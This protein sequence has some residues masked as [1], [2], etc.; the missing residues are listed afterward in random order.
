MA[1]HVPKGTWVEVHR[2]VLE[3][4]ERAPHVPA[5]TSRVPLEMMVK[6]FLMHDATIGTEVEISTL[7]GRILR[8]TL[9]AINPSYAHT[10]GPP[11]PA[12]SSIGAEARVLL[13][14]VRR[15]L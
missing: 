11:I 2:I 14:E 1:N 10:F 12:L 15:A 7:A 4:G 13:S 3:A 5:D 9:T 6:G 8:G